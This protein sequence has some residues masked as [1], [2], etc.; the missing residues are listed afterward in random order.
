MIVPKLMSANDA[1]AGQMRIW[2]A[3]IVQADGIAIATKLD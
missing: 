3:P 1:N 2:Y